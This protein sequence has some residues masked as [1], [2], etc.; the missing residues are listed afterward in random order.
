[1][2][3]WIS[4]PST[5]PTGICWRNLDEDGLDVSLLD[6]NR[7]A[8]LIKADA[9]VAGGMFREEGD[10]FV[11]VCEAFRDGAPPVVAEFDLALVEP[12][13]VAALFEVGLDAA[14]EIF[15]GIAAV[16]EENAERMGRRRRSLSLVTLAA[17]RRNLALL[18][19]NPEL[20]DLTQRLIAL[21][22]ISGHCTFVAKADGVS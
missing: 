8:D 20:A 4:G 21:C 11:A 15:V 16:A 2:H 13:I 6:A 17:T 18:G 7:D 12:D 22:T 3:W 14:D 9:G 1:M 5:G 19:A 10:E